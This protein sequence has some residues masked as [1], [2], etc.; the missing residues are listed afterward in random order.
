MQVLG[1]PELVWRLA[2]FAA[3]FA[4]LSLAE[5]CW[6]RRPRPAPRWQRRAT[7]LGL[8]A[9]GSAALRI[10]AAL[11]V[12]LAATAVALWAEQHDIGLLH[13]LPLPGWL[14]FAVSLLLLDLL[15]WAQHAAFHRLPL[16]W[17]IHRVHHADGEIDSSTGLRF[18]PVEIA[19][20]MGIKCAAV[21]LLGAPALAVMSFEILLNATSI[22][23]HA[24]LRL[25]EPIDR[26][27]R[28]LL[29]TPDMHRVHHST[30]AREQQCNFGFNLSLWDRCFGSYRAAPAA[31][32]LGMQIGL[33]EF[34]SEA[35]DRLGWS[36][37]LPFV[38]VH[39]AEPDSTS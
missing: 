37:R 10:M 13:R 36:L 35:P 23:S 38:D 39:P 19:L 26:W 7:N 28:R 4:T 6:P 21:A 16:L 34:R 27:L 24:N 9:L 8:L 15:L 11:P 33:S 2:A 17:R 31:G 12:P 25:P 3:V 1:I 18:H 32:H 30:D 14:V 29:V 20:S 5:A 22:F